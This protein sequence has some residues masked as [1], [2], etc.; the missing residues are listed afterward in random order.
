MKVGHWFF[1]ISILVSSSV[2][3]ADS[4]TLPLKFKTNPRPDGEP[5]ETKLLDPKD[6]PSA[7]LA[8][9]NKSI[10]QNK[11][12]DHPF[13]ASFDIFG[14]SRV[15]EKVVRE[16]LGGQLDAWF[17]KGVKG[18]PESLEMERAIS[19]KLKAKLNLALVEW[20]IVQIFD[21]GN[22]AL[23]VTLDVVEKSDVARRMPFLPEP[24][25]QYADPANL[26]QSWE[27]YEEIAI[28]LVETGKLNPETVECVAYHCPFGHK[29]PKLKKYERIFVDG[30]AKYHKELEKIATGDAR[31]DF[32]ASAVYLLA[33][34]KDGKKVLSLMVNRI[35]D[36][37]DLVRNNALRVLGDIAQ[38]HTDLVVPVRPVL[39][40]LDFP[41]VSDRTKSIFIVYLMAMASQ[42]SRDEIMKYALPNILALLDTKQPDER[43]VAHVILKKLSGKDFPM[44]AIADWRRWTDRATGDR[45]VSRK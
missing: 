24:T 37:N 1:I 6:G 32:R 28:D 14:S 12:A 15:T 36:P 27:E 13:I 20:S 44:T 11:A 8:K 3:R 30:V 26:I 19:E 42:E 9:R 40:A 38:F 34:L 22:F 25:G 45:Q 5:L 35:R 33:Y 23:H 41:R 39:Q 2:L 29:H 43:D 4:D 10:T 21:P 16:I 18:D 31:P 7:V 17:E